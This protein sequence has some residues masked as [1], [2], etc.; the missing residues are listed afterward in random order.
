[1]ISSY[2]ILCIWLIIPFKILSFATASDRAQTGFGSR[3]AALLNGLHSFPLPGLSHFFHLGLVNFA[4]FA[5]FRTALPRFLYGIGD[6]SSDAALGRDLASPAAEMK[7]GFLSV[8]ASSTNH[9]P[10]FLYFLPKPL[11][12]LSIYTQR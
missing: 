6:A 2:A 10:P 4:F 1:M 8:F 7:D 9:Q 3:P 12:R 11:P 5:A